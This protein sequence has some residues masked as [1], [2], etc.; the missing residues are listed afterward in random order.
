M[1]HL[2]LVKYLTAIVVVFCSITLWARPV[3]AQ[4]SCFPTCSGTDAKMVSTGSFV[5]NSFM[6]PSYY[7]RITVERDRDTF[8]I[9]LFD[10][11]SSNYDAGHHDENTHQQ[12]YTLYA[13][14]DADGEPDDPGS[15]I[16]VWEGNDTALSGG[17]LWS[18]SQSSMPDFDWWNAEIQTTEDARAESGHFFY[19]LSVTTENV[20]D[21]GITT[22]KVRVSG[23]VSVNSRG[24][25]IIGSIMN[26]DDVY[27][28]DYSGDWDLYVYVATTQDEF[29]IWDGDFDYGTDFYLPTIY[30]DTDDPN[31]PGDPFL[32]GW[33]ETL[34]VEFE[35]AKGYGEPMD[36]FWWEI[37][38]EPPPVTY[39]IR[40][41]HG[42]YCTNFNPSGSS[43]WEN[44]V[45]S[46]ITSDPT[47]TDFYTGLPLPRG[48]YRI[49]IAGL[50][51]HNTA[52]FRT[53]YVTLGVNESGNPVTPHAPYIIGHYVWLDADE[54]GVM[55]E[56]EMGFEGVPVNLYDS[57]GV[58]LATTITDSNG[59]YF[60][61]VEGQTIDPFTSQ[62]IYD[63]IYTVIVDPS[64][65]DEEGVL[66]DFY[67]TTESN[68]LTYTVL[69]GNVELYNY[70]Y[71]NEEYREL[72]AE[73]G[74]GVIGPSLVG[75][76]FLRTLQKRLKN[77]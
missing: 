1:K 9:G 14:A 68:E 59:Y 62:V 44:F 31:T 21:W 25:S 49:S 30:E 24:Y 12:I 51:S 10:G 15:P 37:W 4:Y 48:I 56:S 53:P 41:P 27:D 29:D 40:T 70:G 16:A 17:P 11:E 8:E 43:E 34:G 77:P 72:L 28:T 64:N 45:I 39:Q 3:A 5:M 52:F 18:T 7:F 76:L 63:G 75:L 26:W 71:S 60:F 36:D 22:F 32:P 58:L 57:H 54:D 66:S 65:F 6:L 13:D 46:S 23:A 38:R 73:T 67:L 19:L 47:L 61:E 35:G 69:D 42:V 50:D 20:S 55:D 2:Y 74:V 33:V